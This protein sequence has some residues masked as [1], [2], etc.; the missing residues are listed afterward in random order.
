MSE[1]LRLFIAS[2]C[3]GSDRCFRKVVRG[4][5]FYRADLA[6]IAGDLA[7]KDLVVIKRDGNG[8]LARA[9]GAS[10]ST[11]IAEPLDV[12][13]KRLADA[14]C[15]TVLTPDE[16]DPL[17]GRGSRK[18]WQ[19]LFDGAFTRKLDEWRSFAERELGTGA[20]R[21]LWV[22]GNDDAHWMDQ[23]L[24]NAP[25]F[26]LELR[27]F[28]HGNDLHFAGMGGSNPTPWDTPR[29]YAESE[30][31]L[32]L[33]RLVERSSGDG[34]IAVIHVPPHASGLDSAPALKSD[35]SYEMIMGNPVLKPV[36][37]T[38][39]R[40]FIERVQPL[41]VLSG[42]V[43]EARGSTRIGRTLCVNPGS[44]YYSGVLL[45][46]IIEIQNRQIV[47]VEFTEG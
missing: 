27:A 32:R 18:D 12:F 33:D 38:A 47:S 24:E 5:S 39:V 45:G 15:L 37:S 34:M 26:N 36:G 25:F 13:R 29:E 22:P 10:T 41:L 14:G 7:P 35:L 30:I 40:A 44:L 9:A 23:Q 42:H 31:A 21:L 3:H 1:R 8:H 6:V 43:H 2:D 19:Y 16:A 28:K 11:P 46:C 17:T 20:A 4:L